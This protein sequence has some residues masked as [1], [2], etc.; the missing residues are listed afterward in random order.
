[1][2]SEGIDIA[3]LEAPMAQPAAA[4]SVPSLAVRISRSF[5]YLWTTEVH[6]YAFSIAANALL[7]F[8]PFSLLLLTICHSWLHWQGAYDVVVDLLRANLPT[9]ADFVIR[10]LGVVLRLRRQTAVVSVLL[11]FITSSGVFLPLEVAL[12]RIWGFQRNRSYIRNM[13]VSLMLAVG[14]G[15][16]ALVGVTF[17]ALM[18]AILPTSL[19]PAST[20][21]TVLSRA[22]LETISVPVM[23][24]VYFMIYWILPNGKVR[25]ARA[26]R[27]A[28]C[29]AILTEGVRWVFILVLPLLRFPEVYGP[30]AISATLLIWSFLGSLTLLSGASLFAYGHELKVITERRHPEGG[31]RVSV[32]GLED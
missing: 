22:A 20:L 4:G 3:E 31:G 17:G 1:V 11:L 19:F 5:Q 25:I 10:N 29:A 8:F 12:N 15:V 13:A 2:A 28:L 30:F 32:L 24:G 18:L 7:S 16:M 9:G 6:A 27:A 23:I 26:M 21:T 14:S